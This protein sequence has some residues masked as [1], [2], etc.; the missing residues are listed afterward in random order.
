MKK[1]LL[2]VTSAF[3][4]AL[5]ILAACGGPKTFKITWKNGDEVLQVD[6]KVVEGTT[7]TYNGAVPT[8]PSTESMDYTFKG[9]SPAISKV[10]KAAT[11]TAQFEPA[12]KDF[13]VTWKNYDNSILKT[14]NY[15][16]G[17]TPSYKGSDPVKPSTEK[18][19]YIFTGWSPEITE[20]TENATYVAQF[21]EN[22]KKLSKR[23]CAVI[24]VTDEYYKAAETEIAAFAMSY[25]TTVIPIPGKN[26][27]DDIGMKKIK[28]AIEKAVGTDIV[29]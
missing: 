23:G 14:E 17:Q 3:V 11:Y 12:S 2:L 18:F 27:D 4:I 13:T 1:K 25:T 9:W 21:E 29:G 8:K 26:S 22:I 19:N 20:V 28:Q 5:P 7:P 10:T 24:F 15:S 16:Y 6:E